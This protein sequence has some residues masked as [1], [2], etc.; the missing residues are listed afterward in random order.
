MYI[1][2]DCSSLHTFIGDL[3]IEIK[4]RLRLKAN[5]A[6][7][8]NLEENMDINPNNTMNETGIVHNKREAFFD[9]EDLKKR[10]RTDND[11]ILII[12]T[13]NPQLQILVTNAMNR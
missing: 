5:K 8:S 13:A 4:E 2:N 12:I 9:D 6:N 1:T 3:A 7:D 11:K 10:R